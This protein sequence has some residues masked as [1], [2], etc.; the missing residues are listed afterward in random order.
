MYQFENTSLFKT[1]WNATAC[2]SKYF[3]QLN[4]FFDVYIVLS[5]IKKTSGTKHVLGTHSVGLFPIDQRF[6]KNCSACSNT[7]IFLL[8]LHPLVKMQQCGWCIMPC[9]HSKNSDVMKKLAIQSLRNTFFYINH[10]IC[11]NV[12]S[13]FRLK[14]DVTR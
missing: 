8:W 1:G 11:R 2:N 4:Y 6:E 13:R 12:V 7:T 5:L 14:K 10:L 9:F 3:R